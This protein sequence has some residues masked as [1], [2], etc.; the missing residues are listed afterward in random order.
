M[1]LNLNQYFDD[2]GVSFNDGYMYYQ[3]KLKNKKKTDTLLVTAGYFFV[4]SQVEDIETAGLGYLVKYQPK[5]EEKLRENIIS[6]ENINDQKY[7]METFSG[8]GLV[9]IEGKEFYHLFKN[10]VLTCIK[11]NE[12]M[13]VIS[14]T[15]WFDE[16]RIFS[17]GRKLITSHK[18]EKDNYRLK[19]TQDGILSVSGTILEWQCNVFKPA[20]NN[21]HLLA[22]LC[23]SLSTLL[24]DRFDVGTR[25]IHWYGLHGKGKTT[26][27][28]CA[29]S[30]FGN[31]IDP[32][33]SSPNAENP[34]YVTKLNASNAG[35]EALAARY[36]CHPMIADELGEATRLNFSS[37]LY[38][39]SGNSGAVVANT[40]RKLA[41]PLSWMTLVLTTGELSTADYIGKTETVNGG[42]LD[43]AADIPTDS[44]PIFDNTAGFD[45]PYD[46]AAHLK[47]SCAQYYGI[48]AE[49]FIEYLVANPK[50]VI[51]YK[52]ELM[53]EF[54]KELTPA[55]CDG[56]ALR[57]VKVFIAA[58]MTG[59]IAIEAK[60]F[61]CEPEDI[62]N[63]FKTVINLWWKQRT[64]NQPEMRLA[65]YIAENIDKIEQG[66][67]CQE[68]QAT[69]FNINENH[70]LMFREDFNNEFG[71]DAASLLKQLD[72]NEIL[73]TEANNGTR[74]TKRHYSNTRTFSCLTFDINRL[75]P[76]IAL[77]I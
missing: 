28:Q 15:G 8:S 27:L 37:A 25:L 41:A 52:D 75:E 10:S 46:L 22:A 40:K 70:L 3:P 43:R 62:T 68:S 67:P 61:T 65:K 16:Y 33:L 48:A 29:A 57:I 74:L 76:Y 14:R 42:Q 30:V 24:M 21:P 54:E 7:L 17:T 39:L 77:W 18:V 64:S 66:D 2:D 47:K 20:I 12:K 45:S 11:R 32:T 19:C 73:I 38:T 71:S 34:P 72:K 13:K 60:I 9:I 1:T 50:I 63:A 36:H 4:N 31:G 6:A 23:L 58:L 56:G 44:L 55:G 59:L 35:L 69:I 51:K 26:L 49:K 53:A 5:G